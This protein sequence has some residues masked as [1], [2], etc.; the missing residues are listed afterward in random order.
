M[1]LK[2]SEL[3]H[4]KSSYE[5][6]GYLLRLV[7]SLWHRQLNA[8]L[9]KIDLTEMQFVLLIGLGW[10][11]EHQPKGISQ[12]ELAQ[13][14]GCSTAL[15]SQVLQKLVRKELVIVKSDTRDARARVVRLSAAGEIKLKKAVQILD[16]TDAD[17]RKDDPEV[18]ENLYRALRAVAAVKMK[19]TTHPEA[20]FGAMP[21]DGLV[22]LPVDEAEVAAPKPRT[23]RKKAL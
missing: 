15:A 18:F 2:V 21:F 1:A 17:F 22:G 12:K 5:V 6:L 7:S 3:S 19:S 13:A 9:A 14:C 11:T 10:M 20:D 8:E 4:F 23:G 16:Q